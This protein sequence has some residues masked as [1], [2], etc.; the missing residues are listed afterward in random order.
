MFNNLP[1][2]KSKQYVQEWGEPRSKKRFEKLTRSLRA[3]ISSSRGDD[4]HRARVEW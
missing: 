2:V 1:P 4:K 3:F